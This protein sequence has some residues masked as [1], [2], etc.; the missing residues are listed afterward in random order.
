VF[1]YSG[2]FIDKKRPLQTVRAFA[3]ARRGLKMALLM[4]GDGP[5][6]ESARQM[7][8]DERIPDVV[9]AGFL[10]QTEV[11]RAYAAADSLVLFSGDGET[12][13]LVVNEAMNFGLAVIASTKVGSAPDLVEPF[14]NGLVVP[15]DDVP[16]L[17]D[18]L[19]TAATD[20]ERLTTWGDAGLKRIDE[21][22]IG[23]TADGMVAACTHRTVG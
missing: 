15:Y 13:G 20:P 4:A 19:R 11:P 7:V 22:D 17:A 12:W 3:T 14:V 10:N 23:A 9:F 2:K 5:L 1:L 8:A 21:Y 16:A 6:A 18:A